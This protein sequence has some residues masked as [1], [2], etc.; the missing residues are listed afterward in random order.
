MVVV[1]SMVM[2]GVCVCS[3]FKMFKI[4]RVF[5]IDIVWIYKSLFKGC[6]MLVK[7][8]CLF[9]WVFVIFVFCSFLCCM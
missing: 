7:F 5:L 2:C 1:K 3:F 8:V 6:L 4:D 9:S